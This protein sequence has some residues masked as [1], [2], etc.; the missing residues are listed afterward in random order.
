LSGADLSE[1]DLSGADLHGANLN[2]A[3]LHGAILQGVDLK[4]TCLDPSNKP[5][6]NVEG[7]EKDPADANFV[8][9][10]RTYRSTIC[11]SQEYNPG[12]Y[13]APWFS[14]SDTECHPGLYLWP[15]KVLAENWLQHNPCV[16]KIIKVRAL[17]IDVH[18]TDKKWRCK[19]FTVL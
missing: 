6:G 12:E 10:Y 16:E 8:F 5:N 14:T 7:F 9:G 3:N 2:V 13:T 17:A 1:A 15:N 18:K 4:D 19:K 11:G